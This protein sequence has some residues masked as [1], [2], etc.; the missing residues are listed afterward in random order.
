M[1]RAFLLSTLLVVPLLFALTPPGAGTAVAAPAPPAA[2][3]GQLDGKQI[4]LD[5]KCNLCHTVSTA[6]IEAKMK[7]G[8]MAGPDLANVGDRH[9]ADWIA[10]WLRKEAEMDGQKHPKAFTG[11]DEELGALIS[12]LMEQKK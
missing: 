8:K 9:E 6:D 2:G 1:K 7:S 5:S 11:S 4:F 12:W 3:G 10:K